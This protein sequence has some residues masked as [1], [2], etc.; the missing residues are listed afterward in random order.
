MKARRV[1]EVEVGIYAGLQVLH[2]NVIEKFLSFKHNEE[3]ISKI[4][5]Y[6]KRKISKVKI[7][8]FKMLTLIFWCNPYLFKKN[9]KS[10]L[11]IIKA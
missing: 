11:K 4:Y 3:S 1:V 7:F 10:F 6:K 8:L 2:L 5:Y 9:K